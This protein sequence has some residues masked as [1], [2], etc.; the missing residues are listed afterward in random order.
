V[1]YGRVRSLDPDKRPCP[2]RLRARCA[3]A[4]AAGRSRLRAERGSALI[5]VLVGCVVL[6]VATAGILNGIDGAQSVGAKNKARSVQATLAQQDIERMRSMPVSSLDNFT[7]T[8]TLNVAGADYTVVSRTDWVSDK[9]G[10]VNCSNTAAKAEYLKL[11]STVTSAA[12][13]AKT[14]TETGL[15]TPAVGAL[16]TSTGS[17]TVQLTDRN[18]VPLNAVTVTL[19]GASSQSATTNSLGCAVFGYIPVGSYN[20]TIPGYVEMISSAPATSTMQ[21]YTGRA[22][23]TSMQVDRSARVRANFV[24]PVGQ[25]ITTSMVWD[26]IT[27]KNANLT[28]S[29]KTFTNTAG[30]STFVEAPDL[31]PFLDGVGVYAGNCDANDPS[32][33]VPTYFNPSATRGW[34]ALLP[35][36]TLRAVN[37]EMPT[38]RVTVNRQAVTPSAAG[39]T[40]AQVPSWTRTQLMVTQNDGTSCNSVIHSLTNTRTAS[41]TAVQFPIAQPFGH[42]TL[43]ASTRGQ[44][45]TS[46]GGATTIV[47]RK[48]T[49]T[50]NL[51]S[52]IPSTPNRAVTMTTTAATSGVCF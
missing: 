25:T 23:F 44:L 51:T 49:T 41:T 26:T 4:C 45:N 50:V 18:G 5:E 43:C 9:A 8:R 28:G 7:Q 2:A 33:Y 39:T 37:V 13:G 38:L 32:L 10:V 46:A 24:A 48:I 29:K 19:T 20:I 6:A 35:G 22:T 11:T 30:R 40:T 12:T 42:Y 36:D 52:P 27:V 17:A 16:S 14:V 21:V 31:Y 34:T 15:L 3:A 1:V 47:D